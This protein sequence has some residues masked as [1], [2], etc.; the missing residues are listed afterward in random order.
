MGQDDQVG[1]RENPGVSRP[2]RDFEEM[3]ARDADNERRIMWSEIGVAAGLGLVAAIYF[4][5]R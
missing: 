4:I 2:D 3:L 5:L 1:T